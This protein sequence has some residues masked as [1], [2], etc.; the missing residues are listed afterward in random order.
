MTR[1]LLAFAIASIAL[2]QEAPPQWQIAAGGKM[3]F[4][5]ASIKLAAPGA[6]IP[7][8]FPLDAGDAYNATGGRFFATFP[9]ATFIQFAYKLQLTPDQIQAMI[10]PLPKWVATDRFEIEARAAALPNVTKDQMRLMMQSL[11]ADRFKLAAHSETRVMPVFAM[12]LMRPGKTGSSLRPHDAGPPCDKA[13]PP[14]AKDV[15]PPVCNV[16]VLLKGPGGIRAG[17][18]NTTPDLLAAAVAGFD[19]MG[20]PVVDQTG[21]TGRFDFVLEWMPENRATAELGALPPS[22]PQGPTL[23]EGLRDQ[24][25]LKLEPAK[26]PVRVL[27]VD[28]V[29]LPSDN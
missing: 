23:L 18:R 7:P 25:G 22:D 8:A 14:G 27:I 28:H 6:F 12:T 3:T 20:R 24:L 16:Y 10:A 29:E 11:L 17:S 9:L 2:G 19:R 1:R 21:L 5:V 15:F 4:D 13:A 26:A